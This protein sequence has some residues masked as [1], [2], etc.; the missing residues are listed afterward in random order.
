MTSQSY[1][2]LKSKPKFVETK[3]RINRDTLID[4]TNTFQHFMTHTA[5]HL[6]STSFTICRL[7][8]QYVTYFQRHLPL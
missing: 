2:K 3:L 5:C 8:I 1:L 7:V 6:I 4:I